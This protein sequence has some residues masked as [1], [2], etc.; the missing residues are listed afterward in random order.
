MSELIVTMRD[1]RESGL[2]VQGARA[3]FKSRGLDFRKFLHEGM[4]ESQVLALRDAMANRA[5]E[6]ARKRMGGRA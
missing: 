4:P 2:C 1:V 6:V 5:L 3:W